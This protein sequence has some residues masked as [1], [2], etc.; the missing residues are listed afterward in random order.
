MTHPAGRVAGE[1]TV[2][3]TM[4]VASQMSKDGEVNTKQVVADVVFGQIGGE[5]GDKVM[6]KAQTSKTG[7]MLHRQADHARRIAGNK[8]RPSRAQKANEAIQ[9]LNIMVKRLK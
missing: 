3:A 8:P 5:A 1:V 2:D 9:K 6:T 4:S 7:K